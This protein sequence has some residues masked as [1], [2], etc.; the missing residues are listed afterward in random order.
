MA[1][2]AMPAPGTDMPC[3]DTDKKMARFDPSIHTLPHVPVASTAT[4]GFEEPGRMGQAPRPGSASAAAASEVT[5]T[6]DP[7]SQGK[8]AP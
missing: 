1:R 4:E 8:W 6:A 7:D 3:A 2:D 5:V